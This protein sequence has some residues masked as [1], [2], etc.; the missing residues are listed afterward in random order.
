MMT[1]DLTNL[2]AAAADIV[3]DAATIATK[4][5]KDLTISTKA[6]RNDLVTAVDKAVEERIATR[7]AEIA[8]YPLLGEEGHDIDSFA[9]RVWVLDPIDGTLNYVETHRDYAISLALVE[10]GVPIAGLVYD[11]VASRMYEAIRGEG[12]RVNGSLLPRLE[13]RHRDDIVVITDIKE[14]DALPRLRE[15]VTLSRGHRR[16]GS[17]ALECIEVACGRAG[18]F[19]HL[20]VAPWDIAAAILVL[21][22]VGARVSRIDGTPL[23]VRY[24]GSIVAA[25][26]PAH[27]EIIERLVRDAT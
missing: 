6:H 19:V 15:I 20:W 26:D 22:E 5:P 23:D 9:G 10:D 4:P 27:D 2:M 8:P 1:R 24:K 3:R 17:A 18:A 16:Y 14:L 21:T 25:A 11:V 12:A 13:P 7:L